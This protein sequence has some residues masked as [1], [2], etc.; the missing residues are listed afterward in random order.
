[1]TKK[2]RDF[3]VVI[4]L[5]SVISRVGSQCMQEWADGSKMELVWFQHRLS[6]FFISLCLHS[7]ILSKITLS[8]R[9]LSSPQH[10]KTANLSSGIRS[11]KSPVE[12]VNPRG[13]SH[14]YECPLGT[15]EPGWP[16][17]II[18][19]EMMEE[20]IKIMGENSREKTEYVCGA[21]SGWRR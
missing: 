15:T 19:S 20:E 16:R 9:S 14:S 18:P 17:R 4:T 13:E 2:Y 6:G 11:I 21:G 3:Y 7:F 12:W 8:T 10:F 1:M 5:H